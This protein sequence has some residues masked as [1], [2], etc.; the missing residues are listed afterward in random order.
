MYKLTKTI[1]ALVDSKI[2]KN[3]LKE[4]VTCEHMVFD[5]IINEKVNDLFIENSKTIIQYSKVFEYVK[6]LKNLMA[7]S[8]I[9]KMEM[10]SLFGVSNDNVSRIISGYNSD[11]INS[12]FEI[13]DSEFES[14]GLTYYLKNKIPGIKKELLL[15]FQSNNK[16]LKEAIL[17]Y[18]FK[19]KSINVSIFK[20]NVKEYISNN[21]VFLELSDST[22]D[23]AIEELLNNRYIFKV[24]DEYVFPPNVFYDVDI[25][26]SVRESYKSL[27]D[28]DFAYMDGLKM[29]VNGETLKSIGNEL[30]ITREAARQRQNRLSFL[31]NETKEVNKYKDFFEKYKLDKKTFCSLFNEDS[32]I[33]N[34]LNITCQKGKKNVNSEDLLNDDLTNDL[35]ISVDKIRKLFKEPKKRVTK[36]EAVQ[37]FLKRNSNITYNVHDFLTSYNSCH[38]EELQLKTE[39]SVIGII[40]VLENVIS[41]S[42]KTFRFFDLSEKKNMAF[43][44]FDVMSSYKNGEYSTYKVFKENPILM[45]N[46]GVKDEYELYNF[47]KR[48]EDKFYGFH[49]IKSPMILKGFDSKDEFIKYE[50]S[51]CS[52]MV[53]ED[54]ISRIFDEYGLKK[55]SFRV[56]LEASFKNYIYDGKI[57][58]LNKSYNEDIIGSINNKTHDDIYEISEFCEL[59]DVDENVITN[60]FLHEIGYYQTGKF[61][62]KASFGNLKSAVQNMIFQNSDKFYKIYDDDTIKRIII[63][64]ESS[65]RIFEMGNNKFCTIDNLKQ[66]GFSEIDVDNF[67]DKVILVAKNKKYFSIESIYDELNG[68]RLFDY[69]FMETFYDSIIGYS[70]KFTILRRN[71]NN[72][73]RLYTN[74]EG[75]FADFIQTELEL[76]GGKSYMNDY[77]N[78]IGEKYGINLT[79][80]SVQNNVERYANALDKIYNNKI[81]YYK[82][83]E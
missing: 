23:D 2:S 1:G 65:K 26:L 7:F 35:N 47:I 8:T 9:F 76:I 31:F 69:S 30:G 19:E 50:L 4:Y 68:D 27:F 3:K 46:L 6:S 54:F 79:E 41:G 28:L 55:S 60:E 80:N 42:G 34:L 38:D 52:G 24:N 74:G 51:L 21:C 10:L 53:V 16:Y 70:G 14:L 72:D 81:D 33:F 12:L 44:V 64:L 75:N 83:I 71:F 20:N 67:I 40:S 58:D 5:I 39:V 32:R 22:L 66:K 43:Y 48:N 49:L 29:R 37:E 62:Y 11:D 57:L 18:L 13:S 61:L 45:K 36:R 17:F 63:G 77:L 78:Y 56:Y 15:E 73:L 59:M 82:D 25:P